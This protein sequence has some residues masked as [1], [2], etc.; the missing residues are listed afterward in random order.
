MKKWM[1]KE[2]SQWIYYDD[3][4]GK[5][6]GFVYKIGNQ[7]TIWG[8]RVEH[9]NRETVLGQYIDSDYAKKAVVRCWDILDRTMI[10]H[11]DA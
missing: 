10:G 9:E 6:I 7:N 4:D 1:E 2:Y 5:I 11:T 3:Y 8:A